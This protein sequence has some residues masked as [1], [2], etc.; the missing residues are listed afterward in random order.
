VLSVILFAL[1]F[2]CPLL[3]VGI[4]IALRRRLPEHHLSR[5]A[6]DVIK[7][8]MGLM[9]T[10]VALILSLLITSA[11]RQRMA[12]DTEYKQ[13][14]SSIIHLDEYLQAYGPDTRPLREHIRHVAARSFQEHWPG[15][16]FGPTGSEPDTGRNRYVDV[17]RQIASLQ[18]ADPAQRWF[19]SQALQV[20]NRMSDL[21]LLVMSQEATTAPLLPVFTLIFLCTIAIFGS[22]SLYVQPNP[23][24]IT[25]LSLTALAI[26]GS[27]FLIVELNS[28]FYGLLRISSQG[29]H[30]VMH[31]LGP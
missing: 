28:P 13:I 14:L 31:M 18:P 30:I 10:L 5:D 12:I 11:N 25:V 7:L 26:A 9:A 16:D 1:A 15:E 27:T 20:T 4:G 19:Q 8:A 22:F 3:G 17:Q 24:I 6:T 23:T 29:A 2:L 21:R